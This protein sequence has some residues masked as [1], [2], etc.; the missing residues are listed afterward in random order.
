M[1]YVVDS[2]ILQMALKIKQI[3]RS[4]PT[5]VWKLNSKYN[6]KIV[7]INYKITGLQWNTYIYWH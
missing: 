4:L 7:F 1:D 6:K 3:C 5:Y 2:E